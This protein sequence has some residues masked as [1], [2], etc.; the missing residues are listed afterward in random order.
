MRTELDRDQAEERVMSDAGSSSVLRARGLRK[1]YGTGASLVRAVDGV[2]LDV[3][4][5][6]TAA[7]MGPSGSGKSTLLHLLGGLDR[8]TS[9]ELWL[10]GFRIDQASER[11]LARLRR[12]AVGFV[13][14]AFHL[15]DELTAVENVELPVLL[16]GGSPR[17]ARRRAAELLE[18]VGLS[19][20]A[21]FLPSALSGGQRQRVAIARALVNEP[22]LLLADEPTGNLDSEATVD[23]LRLFETLHAAGQTLI[24]VTHDSRIAATADRLIGMR[25]G[26]FVDETRLVGR[27]AAR[28]LRLRRAEAA[29]MLIVITAA[30][31]TLT[32]GL[33]LSGVT[34]NPYLRT[35]ALTSGP[36][37]TAQSAGATKQ[38]MPPA[39]LIALEH[40]PGVTGHSG[41]YP[42]A[43]PVLRANGHDVP[44]GGF[45]VEGRSRS[46]ASIDQ[47]RVIQ[48]SW[49]RPGG[50]VVEPTYATELGVHPRMRITLNGRQFRVVGLAVTAAWPSVNSPGLV[51]T[52]E[53][54]ARSLATTPGS[55]AYTLNLRLRNPVTATAFADAPTASDLFLSSWQQI[56]SQD[57]KEVQFEQQ[58]LVLGS[59]LLGLLAVLSVA[60]LVGGRMAEQNRRVGL[61][62]AVGGT[63]RLV[64][65]VLLAEHLVLAVLAAAAGLTVGWLVAPLLSSPVD[66][67][68]GAPSA[69][70]LSA[71]KVGI[72]AA[73]A[74]LVAVLAT[75]VPALR[76][77]RTSTVASLADAA[78]KPRRRAGLIALS[79]RLPVPLL[80]GTR[81]AARRPRRLVLG[82]ASILITVAMIVGVLALW[83]RDHVSRVPGGLINPIHATVNEVVLVV[84]VVLVVLAAVNA[85]FVAWATVVDSR[86]QV[87]AARALGATQ[88]QV[89]IALAAAQVFPTLLGAVLG[90][91]AGIG[92]IAALSHQPGP[93][94]I[95]PAW[96]LAAVVL[97]A[98][99]VVAGL[100]TIPARIGARRPAA[101]ILQSETA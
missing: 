23:V 12:D 92:L 91:P 66:G 93:L 38:G 50:V 64:A 49:V 36:D 84:T 10:A 96:Q 3:A 56:S 86:H 79:R 82:A 69:P 45:V 35:R 76:A 99:I 41:P 28:D 25:D 21:G 9:G 97:G 48:G 62:K 85:I 74:V 75:F 13:F 59:W 15:M 54:D 42:L 90:I 44:G 6:E 52:T 68:V 5:G 58:A 37:V 77:A 46:P 18:Q 61:L 14:Q 87:A 100:V 65:A 16:A 43:Y 101:E 29:L 95:P 22:L 81:L 32:L 57:S 67:L 80:L 88:E 72:V 83:K 31:A 4:P 71:V 8:P 26:M 19:E 27:L 51:W 73:V 2:D 7:V 33:V 98:P 94:P 34:R 20:R 30:T 17:A 47:P 39:D 11:S 24:I 40:A 60:V 63:P 55:L 78:R 1:E 70:S 89:S 53:A